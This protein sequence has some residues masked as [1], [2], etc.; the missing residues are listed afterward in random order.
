MNIPEFVHLVPRDLQDACSLLQQFPGQSSALAGGTDLLV[1]MKQR[2]VLPRYLV[3]LKKIRGLDYVRHEPGQGLT[4]GPLASIES[5]RNSMVV[6]KK[7]RVLHDAV[8]CMGTLEIRN[9]GTLAGNVCNAS[10]AAETVPALQLLG[11]SA[12]IVRNNGET[13]VPLEAFFLGPGRTLLEPGE[14]VSEICVPE[15]TE[16]AC[17]AYDKF[18]LRRMDLAV[19]GAGVLLRMEGALCREAK[20]ILS[21]VGP[22]AMRVRQ[23]EM[24]LAGNAPDKALIEKA[25]RCAAE[26]IRPQSDLHGTVEQKKEMAASL[27]AR[28]LRQALQ[29]ARKAG[30]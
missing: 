10:P 22:T 28:V 12:R 30:A 11:A 7:Y 16:D 2:R 8:S 21:A 19:V 23:A 26:E 24:L 5:L 20:I 15:P 18:S 9:C 29:R 27:T 1:K 6:K 4:I 14:L 17:G 3:N 13:T 25:A